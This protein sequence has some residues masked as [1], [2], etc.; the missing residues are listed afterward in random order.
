LH[1]NNLFLI[2][3]S[4][5]VF[6][7]LFFGLSVNAQGV[8]EKPTGHDH[9]RKELAK[10]TLASEVILDNKFQEL[11]LLIRNSKYPA[12]LEH[13]AGTADKLT[14]EHQHWLLYAESHCWL[15]SSVYVYPAGSKMSYSEYNACKLEMNQQRI[16]FID[17][18]K[19]EYSG[20]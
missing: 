20:H 18:I 1:D 2:L 12:G 10:S 7:I 14:I 13:N 17:Y 4:Q 19:N 15:V 8:D 5:T 16:Q 6:L 9:A 3:R 11:L